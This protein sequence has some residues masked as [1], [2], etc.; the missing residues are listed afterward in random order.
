MQRGSLGTA[1]GSEPAR[2]REDGES[3]ERGRGEAAAT[4]RSR[5][6]AG[7]IEGSIAGSLEGSIEGS[8]EGSLGELDELR[9]F[10]AQF[11]T[12]LPELEERRRRRLSTLP[13]GRGYPWAVA[14]GTFALLDFGAIMLATLSWRAALAGILV[15]VSFRTYSYRYHVSAVDSERRLLAVTLVVTLL[16]A[17]TQDGWHWHHASWQFAATF[18]A[19]VAAR[20]LGVVIVSVV[21][22]RQPRPALVFGGG[23]MG[24][25]LADTLADHREYGLVPVGFVSDVGVP[26]T[27]LPVVP[28]A[29]AAAAV[30][31]TDVRDV[32]CAFGP[33]SDS[34][35]VR[36]LRELQRRR[37]RLA[38]V[39]RFFDLSPSDD[40]IW[41]IPLQPVRTALPAS[42][43]RAGVKRAIECVLVAI[44]IVVASPV[45]LACAV[46]VKLTSP[47]PVFYKQC[48]IGA[49]GRV[50]EIL[51]FR[52]MRVDAD[53]SRSWT[54]ESD[55]RRTRVGS[56][57]RRWGLDE[58]P[59]LFNV[60]GGD[61]SLVG[62][63]PE[64]PTYAGSFA[65][66]IPT[67]RDRERVRSGLT[68][69]AQVHG[70]RGDTSIDERV[71]FDN[72]YIDRQSLLLDVLIMVKTISAIFRGQGSY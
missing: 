42:R 54:V 31:D 66:E 65:A 61:M 23:A 21:R 41:G 10:D 47:G 34:D 36:V 20:G 3:D 1:D 12:Q 11:G 53:T 57:L 62:P 59:Q 46:A 69:L 29:R 26:A 60:L 67:Y 51:K 6:I 22:R 35:D 50:F 72:R 17:V 13:Y 7:S 27:D 43:L 4:L 70:L 16:A 30:E 55:P 71:R 9:D 14:G 24:M 8:I 5:T 25:L 39:P 45:L 68:G 52:S 44:A 28:L 38:L 19:L 64:Q 49:D 15:S 48:R 33:E 63:R 37:I 58:L 32:I 18:V 40:H 56:F 2:R